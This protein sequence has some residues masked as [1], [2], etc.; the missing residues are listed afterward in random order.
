MRRALCL[1]LALAAAACQKNETTPRGTELLSWSAAQASRKSVAAAK[2]VGPR[3]IKDMTVH[4]RPD[5]KGAVKIA[6][7]VEAAPIEL[8]EGATTARR[9]APLAVRGTLAQNADWTLTANCGD[10]PN[11]RLPTMVA[12]SPVTPEDMLLGCHVYMKYL[13][14]FNDL[15]FAVSLE[16][17]G[18]GTVKPSMLSGTVSLE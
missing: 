3:V 10:G 14:T 17:S 4:M 7:H 6:L 11:L 12:G 18:D 13:D 8:V 2:E 9:T 1:L 16:I 15:T 5:H